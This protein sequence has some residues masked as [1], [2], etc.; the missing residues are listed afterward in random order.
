MKIVR[1]ISEWKR[2]HIKS[3]DK[4]TV[5]T[6]QLFTSMTTN[7]RY[8]HRVTENHNCYHVTRKDT[9]RSKPEMEE[10]IGNVKDR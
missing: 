6:A 10:S 5:S 3:S 4:P 9:M 7:T 8:K 2:Y 1:D